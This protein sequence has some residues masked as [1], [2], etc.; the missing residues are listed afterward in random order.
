MNNDIEFITVEDA[1]LIHA[2][3]IEQYGGASGIRNH[4]LL[5]A[6][7]AA[8]QSTFD[9]SFLYTDMFEMV[10]TYAFHISQNQPFF[11]GNKRTGLLTAL[12]FLDLNG[13]SLNRS[14]VDLYNIM[15]DIAE[16]RKDKDDLTALLQSLAQ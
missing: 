5:K 6:A 14:T 2:L 10:A 15:I 7:V 9:G 3:L 4:K 12:I 11:D 16:G 1:L 8:P 13:I